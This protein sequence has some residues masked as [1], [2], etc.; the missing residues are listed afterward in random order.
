VL[1]GCHH[2]SILGELSRPD[3]ALTRELLA[4]I[5]Y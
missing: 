4:L 1:P 3:G 5:D 2:Y